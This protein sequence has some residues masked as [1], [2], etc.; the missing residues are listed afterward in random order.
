M[1]TSASDDRSVAE[2]VRAALAQHEKYLAWCRGAG[3]WLEPVPSRPASPAM[4]WDWLRFL[5]MERDRLRAG[6][7]ALVPFMAHYADLLNQY[8]G[9]Q[10]TAFASADEWLARLDELAAKKA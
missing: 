3:T 9:G 4:L 8:D 5:L 1:T 10:R 2:Q 6:L 7:E